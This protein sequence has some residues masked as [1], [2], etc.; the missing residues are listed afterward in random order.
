MSM[1]FM[2]EPYGIV[3]E[4]NKIY[5]YNYEKQEIE[6]TF[7]TEGEVPQDFCVRLSLGQVIDSEKLIQEMTH[8]EKSIFLKLVKENRSRYFEQVDVIDEASIKKEILRYEADRIGNNYAN[9][10]PCNARY[11]V[12]KKLKENVEK[13]A[14]IV[15]G[16]GAIGIELMEQLLYYSWAGLYLL[17]N[18]VITEKDIFYSR[19]YLKENLGK[20]RA[21]I[22]KQEKSE[23][24]ILEN[25]NDVVKL[26]KEYLYIHV[27]YT[28]ECPSGK[29]LKSI[30]EYMEKNKIAWSLLTADNVRLIVGPTLYPGQTGCLFCNFDLDNMH[31]QYNLMG[32]EVSLMVGIFMS[33]IGKI[34]GIMQESIV[35]DI[36]VTIGRAF[37]INRRT[38]EGSSIDMERQVECCVC[39]SKSINYT[40]KTVDVTNNII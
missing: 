18:E 7:I 25:L 35:E 1:L 12:Y 38:M 23:I 8:L 16:A 22:L 24:N 20:K 10:V 17:D 28:A 30:N 29:E 19:L 3:Y 31:N 6:K 37:F 2:K 15:C 9:S 4:G 39:G 34:I 11:K 21:I 32:Y 13:T 14:I 33:D 40:S 26:Q 5:L 27:I 36:S